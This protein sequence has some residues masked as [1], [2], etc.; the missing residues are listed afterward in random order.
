MKTTTKQRAADAIKA[1][2]GK[3]N[4]AIAAEIGVDHKTVAKARG[5]N[6]PSETVVGRDGKQYPAKRRAKIGGVSPAANDP[7]A[8]ARRFAAEFEAR[9]KG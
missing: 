2:P 4:R 7:L 6:S 3:S 9:R 1:N 5:D 8:A